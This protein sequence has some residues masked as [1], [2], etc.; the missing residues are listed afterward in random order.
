[1]AGVLDAVHHD[2][3]AGRDLADGGGDGS[4]VH[5]H[6]G[7]GRGV[8]DGGKA[9]IGGDVA[10]IGGN[11][12]VARR[13]VMRDQHM[14]AASDLR[15]ARHGAA[16][17]RVLQ[18]GGEHDAAWFGTQCRR[19]DQAEEHFRSALADEDLAGWRV[20]E[21]PHV[22]LAAGDRR[23]QRG[24]GGIVAALVIRDRGVECGG[25]HHGFEG[26][27]AAR[28]LE[29]HAGARERAIIDMGEAAAHV[30]HQ[31]R[32]VCQHC[33]Y[34]T[35]AGITSLQKSS[36]ERFCSLRPSPRLA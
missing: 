26:E 9:H 15:P 35:K 21:Q 32:L 23:H 16:R 3:A 29:E 24:G 7:N 22:V 33:T 17:C 27:G 1:M 30:F 11:I 18:R 4:H 8:D 2:E 12:D 19:A 31:A 6:A 34:S 25:L 5:R 20:E 36:S 10:E 14:R 13:I 28:I